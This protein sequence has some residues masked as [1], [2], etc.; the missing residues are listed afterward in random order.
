MGERMIR[1]EQKG[2]KE[3][4]GMREMIGL[5][6]TRVT[7]G[8]SGRKQMKQMKR[9]IIVIMLV[10]L[11]AGTVSPSGARR[12]LAADTTAPGAPTNVMSTWRTGDAVR[13]VWDIPSDDTGVVEYDIYLDGVLDGSASG[14]PVYEIGGLTAGSVYSVTVR[15]KDAAGNISVESTAL[16]IN[17]EELD[18]SLWLASA[19]NS[20][21][22]PTLAID[23]LNSTR[24]TSGLA[25]AAD[26]WFQIDTGPAAKSYDQLVVSTS[27]S[28]DYLRGYK[29]A[30][31]D[32]G[33]VWS[34]PIAQGAGSVALTASFPE[35]TSRYLRVTLTS[36]TGSWWSIHNLKLYGSTEVDMIVPQTTTDLSV[37]TL[38]DSEA[39]LTWT[40]APDDVAV[41]GYEINVNGMFVA[42]SKTAGYSVKG[43]Q[44]KT[45]YTFTIK[46]LDYAGNGSAVS[47]AIEATT[48]ERID[49]TLWSASASHNNG[50]AGNGIDGNASS[51]WSSGA[52]QSV[53][54]WYQ[55]DTGPGDKAYNKLVLDTAGSG[56]DYAR[57]FSVTVSDDGVNWSAPVATVNGASAILTAT[58]PEQSAKY[59][60]VTVTKTAGNFWS[61]H[62]AY[63]YGAVAPDETLPTTPSGI[64]IKNVRDTEADINWNASEDNVAVV[65]YNLYANDVFKGYTTG[66]VYKV[67]GL[68]PETTYDLTVRAKDLSGNLSVASAP[69]SM[70]TS[71]LIEAPLI[72]KY[73]MEPDPSDP[74]RLIDSSG[75][76]QNGT[77]TAPAAFVDGRP[78]GG[79]ALSLSGPSQARTLNTNMMNQISSEL[80]M[81][82]WI[83]PDDLVGYQPIATK[84]DANWK[85]T[86]F[87]LGL[88]NGSLYFGGDYGE[89]WYSW[90]FAS[91]EIKADEWTHLSVV[92]ERYVGARFY[93]NGK[94]IGVIDNWAV[95]T[96]LL[97]NDL[98][99]Q[100]GREWHWD[101]TTRSMKEWGFRGQ[102]DSLRMYAAPLT[103]DQVQADMSNT[104]ATRQAT[105]DDFDPASKYSTLRLV[106]FDMPT[107]LFT[108]G[109]AR[110]HQN[111][112]RVTG[113]NAVDWPKIT[114]DIPYP[115]INWTR[116]VEPFTAGAE[117]KTEL[118]L[119]QMPDNMSLIQQPYDNVLEPGNHWLRGV[120][121]RWGQT[122]L[123]TSD[124]T[125]RS[126]S[127]D[128]ELWTFPVKISSDTSGA[129]KNVVLTY[130]GEEIYNSGTN[131]HDSLTLLL[132]QNEVGK[133]YV[134]T[135]DGRDPVSFDAGLIPIVA[136]DPKDEMLSFSLQ[137]PGSGPAIN[138]AS[139]NRPDTF[140]HQ[141]KWEMDE[142]ALSSAKPTALPSMAAGTPSIED[143]V[144]ITVPRSP[145]TINFVYLPHG[146]S[147]GGFFHSEHKEIADQYKNTGTAADYASYVADTG[148]DRVF[149]FTSF[150]DPSEATSYEN[151]ARELAQQGVQFG[152]MPKTDW[153]TITASSQNLPFYS[154]YIA[155]YHAPLYRDIQL[156]LQRLSAYPNIAGISLGADNAGYASYWDWAPPHPN[157][158][159]AR[160][161]EPF[162]STAGRPITAPLAPS[163]QGY[164]PKAQEYFATTTKPFLDYIAE[165]NE[166]YKEFGYFADAVSEVSGDLVTTTGSYGSGPGVGAR[167][168]WVWATIPG[169]E[170]HEN[171]PVQSAYDWNELASSKPLHNVSLIDRLRSYYPNKTTWALQDDFLLFHDKMDREKNY[172]MTLT[173]GIQAIGTNVLVNDKGSL[174][175]P[176]MIAE[177]K[178]LY[179]WIHRYGG[180]Y[181]MTDPTP[182]IGIMYVNE[183]ALLRRIVAGAAPSDAELLAGSHEGKATEALFLTHAAGWPSKLITPEEMK[184]GLPSS[185]KAV[186]LVGLNEFD[187]SWHWYDGL[188]AELEAFVSA[189]GVVLTDD[190]S[191]SP[192][193]STQTSMQVRSYIVQNNVD[194]TNVM[195]SRNGDNIVKLQTAMAGIDS[196]IATTSSET[197]WAVPTRAGD[198][199]YVTVLNQ[200]HDPTAGQTQ[201]LLGQ[202]STLEWHTERP[203]YD[204]RLGR[205]LTAVEAQTVD[206]T[207]NGFQYYAL[208]PAVVV[209]PEVTVE[210]SAS[211]F[212][213]A[214]TTV[215]NPDPMS[216]IPL[217]YT[218]T[219]STSGDTAAVYSATGLTAKLPL[220]MTDAPGEYTIVAEELLSG[221]TTSISVTIAPPNVP[222]A[223]AV[224]LDD[225]D[226]LRAFA[227]RKEQPLVVALT[228]GQANDTS[229]VAEANRLVSYYASIGR[230]VS[231]GSAEAGGVVRGL[232][233][234]QTLM[235]YP[236]WKTEDLD[237]V[238]FGTSSNNVLLL[239]QARAYL[240]DEHG[241]GLSAGGAYVNITKSPFVGEYQALNIVTGDIT[242]LSA[243]IDALIGLPAAS[244]KAPLGLTTT[245]LTDTSVSIAWKSRADADGYL[246]ER[247]NNGSNM[248]HTV[249]SVAAGTTTIEDV[250]LTPD[251][252]YQYR[253]TSLGGAGDSQHSEAIRIITLGAQNVVDP[254]APLD[255]TGWTATA[256]HASYNAG[257]AL[258]GLANT[259][260][261][262]G[263]HMTNGMWYQ[264]DMQMERTLDKLVLDATNSS[265]DYPR[266]YEVYVSNDAINWG[267]AI[268]S[269][270]GSAVTTIDFP[271]Q[272]ARYVKF[273]Q[274]G[275]VG[276]Y[277][278]IHELNVYHTGT[279]SVDSIAP[280]AP[281]GLSVLVDPDHTVKLSWLDATDNVGISGYD[282]FNGSEREN[283]GLIQE[284]S[285]TVTGLTYGTYTFEVRA[286]DLSGNV[287]EASAPVTIVLESQ[288]APSVLL[289]S[290][291]W[292]ATAS[293]ATNQAH[294]G[295]DGKPTTNWKSKAAQGDS[296]Y[297][298]LDMLMVRTINK[299]ILDT[300]RRTGEYLGAYEVYVS[301]D[302][303][304]WGEQIASGIGDLVTTIEFPTIMARYIRIVTV[305]E[306]DADWSIDEMHVYGSIEL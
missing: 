306:T 25:Q 26:Q 196:P 192:V 271:A 110:I 249:L 203:I 33:V 13:L 286:I 304:N 226:D 88:N 242:G 169:K 187:D 138:V 89:K 31:S 167:G 65:G 154:S 143:H 205:Q 194:Q 250:G 181:A 277:W 14:A 44:P 93:A 87:Y 180:A 256:S 98:N 128:Y 207:T 114:L 269:G 12:A 245:V 227:V 73:E 191:V 4:R 291:G 244:P 84:R 223:P 267:T 134:L 74:L 142:A 170:M 80:T 113:E 2:M 69:V 215:R 79:K 85:G 48:K 202:T 235:K 56:G 182:T 297:Y 201:H 24:W 228:D 1:I 101:T 107:G 153:D 8:M 106:R 71:S 115:E 68:T 261:S 78:G 140:P 284:T 51:R 172:A 270:V 66:L 28:G 60:R 178:E 197:I 189:G 204:V 155:D 190:E 27:S 247:Q 125:A 179:D 147:S 29:V 264:L 212:Y 11:V 288:E 112:V 10:V 32:D 42:F 63:L 168:G 272:T 208:P 62:E 259:R 263:T 144:G 243:A 41:L 175:K 224:Q 21:A 177:Q 303:H 121:W 132:P 183:Q 234:Y 210:V 255:R 299:L 118:M 20:S 92:F 54:M 236:Q 220:S 216:G 251:T 82:A 150:A 5:G 70:T 294:K 17:L 43:L 260:W 275:S 158:P 300:I 39:S 162:R 222:N 293:H 290:S 246:V 123:Y 219:H 279:A 185:M 102:I 46:A 148:Y 40:P 91:S 232:Q 301:N 111:A 126:W 129:V 171:L 38:T 90:S 266:G 76:G 198:T 152:V 200:M 159:W 81:T 282:V 127:W 109:S 274:T 186:L 287:S 231:M 199:Q 233:E 103:F 176:Q 119:K 157:R 37:A 6:G 35:Q 238:L 265:S 278:S 137:V 45:S 240:L 292:V 206:L 59:V 149:E 214:N 305:G 19:S 164:T 193:P 145:E 105:L 217:A 136:G 241:E 53:G 209:A 7:R 268:D 225:E 188:E 258:D 96:S 237:I 184:R 47:N 52:A 239:D 75:L 61:I 160:A 230:N 276:L 86:T 165:Y 229:I 273:V 161:Y 253:V 30:V 108:K 213:E 100:I 77:I 151:V 254:N 18:R 156:G 16:S 34:E 146:M 72:A 116:T 67:T 120:A 298:Q 57:G 257:Y 163:L 58:F 252:F 302:G 285:Y 139:V 83:K 174:A 218:I 166:T 94:L 122:N 64:T 97:P 295:I 36:G 248:W 131:V 221:L 9:W 141:A 296:I 23:N 95:F 135:V 280:E 22:S 283:E 289:E 15:A 99:M 55:I 50:S 117:F 124:R 262:S 133:P 49:R 195:L 104:I 211:G 173:R 281:S 130:D 3:M